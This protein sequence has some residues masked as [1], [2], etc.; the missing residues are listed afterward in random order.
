MH[1]FSFSSLARKFVSFF[2]FLHLY[3]FVF[4][5]LVAHIHSYQTPLHLHLSFWNA[6]AGGNSSESNEG[7]E[8]FIGGAPG[9]TVFVGTLFFFGKLEVVEIE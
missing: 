3:R 8:K 2:N 4:L 6:G 1:V 9:D 5:Y 7:G